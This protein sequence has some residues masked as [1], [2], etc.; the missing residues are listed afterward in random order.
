[1]QRY[2]LHLSYNG[3]VYYGWQ[4]QK[5]TT[6][7]I[8]QVLQDKLSVVLSETIKLTGCGRTDTGVHAKDFYAHFDCAQEDL[9]S[10]ENKWL[11]KFNAVLP[12]DIV[13]HKI[14]KVDSEAN[15]RFDAVSRTYNYI[16][17][18][19]KNPFLI[20]T[21]YWNHTAFDIEKMNAAAASLFEYLDFSSFSKS[22]TKTLT[23]NCKIKEAY[24]KQEGDLLIFTITADRFLR[25]MVRAIV[26]TLLEV[27]VNKIT[28]DEFK[29][30][31]ESKNRSN[32]GASV[33][34]CGLFLTKVEYPETVLIKK[35]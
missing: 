15:A 20:N 23:N 9:T 2:F 6:N 33:P 3:T 35:N 12:A 13:I 29:Q 1:M 30:I 17:T 21:A 22:K 8:Q 32:A 4:I 19:T 25:N 26:G 16:I 5:L 14:I 18:K 7:T 28:V 24:W 11:Y 10:N 27:G 34:A 31:I